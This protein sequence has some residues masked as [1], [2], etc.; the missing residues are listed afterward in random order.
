[1]S[2]QPTSA[3]ILDRLRENPFN[4]PLGR[5]LRMIALFHPVADPWTGEGARGDRGVRSMANLEIPLTEC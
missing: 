1:M 4:A 2:R 5:E 3:E